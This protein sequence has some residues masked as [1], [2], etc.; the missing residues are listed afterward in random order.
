MVDIQE[1]FLSLMLDDGSTRDDVKLPDND[2]GKEIKE[3]FDSGSEFMVTILA[4]CGN[5]AAIAIKT[6]AK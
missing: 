2:L 5:E 3:K 4:S 6:M 1:N